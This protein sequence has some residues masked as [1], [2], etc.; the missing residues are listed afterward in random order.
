[1]LSRALGVQGRSAGWGF[2]DTP[3]PGRTSGQNQGPPLPSR[4]FPRHVSPP[5]SSVV[6][7]SRTRGHAEGGGVWGTRGRPWLQG[8]RGGKAGART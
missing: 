2:P 6:L 8:G 4:T 5:L 7:T 1:M 3:A